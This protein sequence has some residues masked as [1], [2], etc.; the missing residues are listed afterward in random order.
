MNPGHAGARPVAVLSYYNVNEA[1]SGGTRR[2]SEL[3]N[4]IGPDRAWLLQPR[5]VHP[6]F[7]T[8]GFRPDFGARRVGINWGMF[9]FFW[10]P[11]ARRV[12]RWIA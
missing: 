10:P 4:A 9:N 1:C 2:V 8:D 12:R 5:P 11:T 3:L 7:R 6:A